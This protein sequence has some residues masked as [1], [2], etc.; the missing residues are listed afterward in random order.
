MISCTTAPLRFRPLPWPCPLFT[1]PLSALPCPSSPKS[2][3]VTGQEWAATFLN[4][5]G[6]VVDDGGT[7]WRVDGACLSRQKSVFLAQG[8]HHLVAEKWSFLSEVSYLQAVCKWA[9]IKSR[10]LWVCVGVCLGAGVVF[11]D[12][13]TSSK[14]FLYFHRLFYSR[15]FLRFLVKVEILSIFNLWNYLYLFLQL[16]PPLYHWVKTFEMWC[17]WISSLYILIQNLTLPSLQTGA[18]S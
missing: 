11:V 18:A 17:I 13:S 14:L 9:R 5:T 16:L 10:A 12:C 6:L 7:C 2:K 3:L 8:T 1:S 15:C 4:K